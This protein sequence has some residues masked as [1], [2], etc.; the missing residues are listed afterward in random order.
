VFSMALESKGFGAGS[1]RTYFLHIALGGRDVLVLAI[2]VLIMA[3]CITLRVMGYG[4]L[5]GFSL[6]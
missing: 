2:F 3:G 5:Q 6:T 1:R 4:E